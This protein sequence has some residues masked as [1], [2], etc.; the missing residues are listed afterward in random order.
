MLRTAGTR[1]VD[2]AYT[3]PPSGRGS[4][5]EDMLRRPTRVT[6]I[7]DEPKP[8]YSVRGLTAAVGMMFALTALSPADTVRAASASENGKLFRSQRPGALLASHLIPIR[9]EMSEY[10]NLKDGWDGVGSIVPKAGAIATALAFLESLPISARPPE[11][12]VS[13]DGSVGWFWMTPEA[14]ISVNFSGGDRFAYYG[15]A[16]GQ[17]ARGAYAFAGAV[18]QDLLDVI[19]LA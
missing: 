11:P 5:T 6:Y 3:R 14:Y 9:S 15:S 13:A 2:P 10:A 16:G 17:E 8:A 4:T 18:P 12:T 7:P 1:G 19:A